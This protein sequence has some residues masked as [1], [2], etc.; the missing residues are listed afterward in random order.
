MK[1]GLRTKIAGGIGVAAVA[2]AV[3]ATARP[4]TSLP[5]EV[6]LEAAGAN[7]TEAALWLAPTTDPVPGSDLS[8]GVSMLAASRPA[9][10]IPFFSRALPH[11]LLGAYA[12]LYIG[13]A[14]Y[15]LGRYDEA[16]QSARQVVK[17]SPGGAVGEASLWLLAEALEARS[18][19]GDA[20]GIWQTL[21][22]I[23][24]P[25]L[26]EV[27]L[28]LAT[29]ATR[30]G[31]Q[32]VARGAYSTIYYQYPASPEA[33]TAAT[34]L[35]KWPGGPIGA[36]PA[37]LELGRAE[38]LF[39][40]RRYADAKK[41][42]QPLL[43]GPMKAVAA[44]RIAASEFHLKRYTA[45]RDALRAILDAPGAG[46]NI[47]AEYYWLG[48]LRELKRTPEYLAAVPR[49]VE[50]YNAHP[51]AEAALNDLATHFILND[52]DRSAAQTFSMQY[53]I[54][55]SGAFADRAAWKAGW[56]AYRTGDYREAIRLFESAAVT[57]RRADYRPSW[58]YWAAKAHDALGER[59]AAIAGF[60][61][62]ITFYRNSYYGREA[63]RELARLMPRSVTLASSSSSAAALPAAVV[64]GSR[65]ANAPLIEA[66]LSAA[67]YDDAI[68]EVQRVARDTANAPIL[69]ATIAY[70]L[71]RKGELR[72]GITAMRR[73]YPQ[74]MAEGGENLPPRILRVIFPVAYQ[75]LIQ[76][77]AEQR[78]IDPFLLTALV[79]QESTFQ[80]DVRSAANAWGLMQLLP[81]TGRRIGASIGVHGVTTSR[82]TDPDTNVRIGT[83]YL[84]GLLKQFGD[85]AKALAAYNAGENRVERWQA[86][87]PGADRDEFVDDIPF[88]ETQ[89]YVKRIIG[90]SEDY[91]I[92]YGSPSAS[93]VRQ[94]AR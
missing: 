66:L 86:E 42:F 6:A 22:G 51:R 72:P 82:L 37:R 49:F 9:E 20:V 71:N 73:A 62:T 33:A 32:D 64:P 79:A 38:K 93:L 5:T 12:R 26:A 8:L 55:P 68:A 87:R 10:A 40:A 41:A 13:R 56:W 74:F 21:A 35:L 29:A 89:N 2:V 23:D 44:M 84:A 81:S 19:W 63:A 80:A 54:F 60:R 69:D 17:T 36:D 58:L 88:P 30:A 67:L 48:T 1:Y 70:A 75:A 25:R 90:T 57:H 65:P 28:R 27:H 52:D 4:A 45:A 53:A 43:S 91:R 11:P 83:A 59:E 85:V 76:R 47:E 94:S 34:A 61:Q 31:D 46:S 7:L 15:A 18:S 14:Q 39:A 16:I 50:R 78:D 3:L 24:S 92:L 77:Y